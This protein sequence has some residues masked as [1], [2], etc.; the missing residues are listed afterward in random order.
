M[1]H[2]LTI[3]T[4][5]WVRTQT[6]EPQFIYATAAETLGQLLDELVATRPGWAALAPR[7]GEIRFARDQVFASWD[8]PIAGA[9]EVAFFPPVTG[10]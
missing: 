10:G 7:R 9:R 8:T 3:L 5:A 2:D 4:F 1:S 6:G